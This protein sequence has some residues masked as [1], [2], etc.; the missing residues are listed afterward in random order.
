MK[1]FLSLGLIGILLLLASS[2]F[3][4]HISF[5]P[6]QL[7]AAQ[8]GDTVTIEAI[9]TLD[10]RRCVLEDDDVNLE[11]SDH[12]KILSDTGWERMNGNEIHN[13][14]EVQI[15]KPGE[16]TLRVYRECSKKGLSEGSFTFHITE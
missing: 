11:I 15:L 12:L 10:H 6:Q 4:C 3:A 14:F 5:E 8:V 13:S 7:N 1:T 16:A 2:S 9:V